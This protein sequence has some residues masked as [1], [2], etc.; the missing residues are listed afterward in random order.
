MLA[1]SLTL[2]QRAQGWATVPTP[3]P[4]PLTLA[5]A[6]SPCWCSAK[7]SE[8][9]CGGRQA[10]KNRRSAS[11]TGQHCQTARYVPRRAAA[12]AAA[13]ASIQRDP[14]SHDLGRQ[15]HGVAAFGKINCSWNGASPH[16]LGALG[17]SRPS[18]TG[19]G[20]CCDPWVLYVVSFREVCK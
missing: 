6:L 8:R 18:L 10:A 11:R 5:L 14:L 4:S 15:K 2:P 13:A 3:H 16:L 12:A 7:T 19:R 17:A 20:C 9:S 1:K